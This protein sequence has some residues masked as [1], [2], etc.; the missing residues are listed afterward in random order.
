LI[1]ISQAG[2][3]LVQDDVDRPRRVAN[4][5][6]DGSGARRAHPAYIQIGRRIG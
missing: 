3:Q 6:A 1:G 5:K 2:N 4:V